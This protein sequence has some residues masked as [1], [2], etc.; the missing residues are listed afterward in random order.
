[1][2]RRQRA[3]LPQPLVLDWDSLGLWEVAG[4]GQFLKL[5]GRDRGCR[6]RHW[7]VVSCTKN[8]EK[9]RGA[10]T[11]E[12]LQ[13]RTDILP[14]AK[15][16]EGA[17]TVV[18]HEKGIEATTSGNWKVMGRSW[19]RCF[20]I[21]QD[22]DLEAVGQCCRKRRRICAGERLQV[23]PVPTCCSSS[24]ATASPPPGS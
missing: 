18:G 16:S 15:H 1:M 20:L 10:A 2:T 8:R 21:D 14:R 24:L 11:A 7:V 4:R 6:L 5:L 17:G 13:V 23:S 19:F 3:N 12:R 22:T 9:A